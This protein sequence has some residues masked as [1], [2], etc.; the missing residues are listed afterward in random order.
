MKNEL[1]DPCRFSHYCFL[2][3]YGCLKVK[4]ATKEE[5]KEAAK[6][7]KEHRKRLGLK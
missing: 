7:L 3:C 6:D 5:L 2:N 4:Q 1:N